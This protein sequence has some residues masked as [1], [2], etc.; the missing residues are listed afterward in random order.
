M[1]TIY[2]ITQAYG[3]KG[4]QVVTIKRR[5]AILTGSGFHYLSLGGLNLL[6]QTLCFSYDKH[7][8]NLPASDT[9]S[10]AY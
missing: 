1:E 10:G 5:A 4:R 6:V 9:S 8:R 7:A 2:R 3:Q